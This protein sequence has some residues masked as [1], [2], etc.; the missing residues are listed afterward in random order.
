MDADMQVFKN[1]EELWN[2]PFNSAKVLVQKEIKH[3]NV[4]MNKD[5][6]PQK[7]IKQCAVMLLDCSR[8][9]WDINN[10][11]RN[12]DEGKYTYE[13]LMYEMCI[14]PENEVGYTVPFEWNSLEYFDQNT[15]LIHYTDM[16]TQPWVSPPKTRMV[17]SGLKKYEGCWR[18]ALCLGKF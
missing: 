11:V 16:G 5:N 12:M 13:E 4:S 15:R 17:T 3:L 18:T 9:D 10:I 1:I 6:T 8:L 7:R 2:L 14:L